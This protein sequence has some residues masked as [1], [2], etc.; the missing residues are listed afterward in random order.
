MDY[1]ERIKLIKSKKKITNGQ[2][3][4]MTGIPL[5]TLSKLLAGMNDSPKLSNM[6]AISEALGCSLDYLV[7]GVSD[8]DFNIRLDEDELA[9]IKKFRE[10][11]DCGKDVTNFVVERE[12][13]RV[14]E[15]RVIPKVIYSASDKT[16][17]RTP[18]IHLRC[19]FLIVR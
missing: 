2:L 4:E 15:T 16:Q 5:G 19:S 11:D 1:I 9:L 8:T 13:K 7:N 14:N 17:K 12:A 3:S 6:I 10:L 18:Q